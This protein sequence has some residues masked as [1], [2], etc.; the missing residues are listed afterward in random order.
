MTGRL[1]INYRSPT[2]LDTPL[3]WEGT[4]D[5]VDG[6]KI[7]TSGRVFNA[8]TGTLLAEAE[9][10]FISVD[11]ARLTSEMAPPGFAAHVPPGNPTNPNPSETA[12]PA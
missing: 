8:D 2:P 12:E 1:S 9:G 10:L 11:F 5:R 3:R 6:R 7:Y 4:M